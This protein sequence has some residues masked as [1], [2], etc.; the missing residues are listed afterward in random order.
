[1][2]QNCN[3]SSSSSREFLLRREKEAASSP[4]CTP[5]MLPLRSLSLPSRPLPLSFLPLHQTSAASKLCVHRLCCCCCLKIVR[6]PPLL[7]LLPQNCASTAS[8]VA[9]V[10]GRGIS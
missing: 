8:A 5:F 3:K 2:A 6:P 4:L 7:L 10:V 1:M 9:T